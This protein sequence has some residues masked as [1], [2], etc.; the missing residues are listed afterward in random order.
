MAHIPFDPPSLPLLRGSRVNTSGGGA[1]NE[2]GAANVPAVT[3]TAEPT[4]ETAPARAPL[5]TSF[6]LT[7]WLLLAGIAGVWGSS[8]LLI[9]KGL[10]AFSPPVIAFLRVGLGALTLAWFPK[11]RAPVARSDLRAIVLLGVLWMA[12]PLTLFPIAQQW[13]DSSLAGMINGGVPIFAAVVSVGVRRKVPSRAQLAGVVVGFLGVVAISA[14]AAQGARSTALGALLVLV[15]TMS[16][17]VALNVAEPLQ[18]RHGSLPVLLRAQLVAVALTAVPAAAG[19]GDSTFS[20]GSAAAMVPLGCLGTG[21]A[22]VAMATLVGRTGAARGSIAIYFVP[23]VAI[24][25]GAAFADESIAPISLAGTAL[26]IAGA[27]LA[28]R[29][30][31]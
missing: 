25:L 17:G 15:A 6:A 29:R 28:G 31:R 23:V 18:R 9:E 30:G 26:V 11:A 21:L 10:E 8:F 14:P 5:A 2:P 16:Y 24:L 1:G 12:L 4:T 13:I 20:W 27:A 3:S 22:F 19:L 7:D